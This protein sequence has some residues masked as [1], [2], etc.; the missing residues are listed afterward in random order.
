MFDGMSHNSW[1]LKLLDGTKR[2]A[3]RNAI[4]TGGISG[5]LNLRA[6]EFEFPG[7]AA[8]IDNLFA[9]AFLGRMLITLSRYLGESILSPNKSLGSPIEAYLYYAILAECFDLDVE[10]LSEK[11]EGSYRLLSPCNPPCARLFIDAQKQL[12]PY[13]VDFCLQGEAIPRKGNP[14]TPIVVECDGHDFHERDK[15]QVSKD[16]KRDRDLQQ[17]GFT[18][19]RYSGSD[20][21]KSLCVHAHEIVYA[22]CFSGNPVE[23]KE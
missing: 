11:P 23:G 7:R 13:R 15:E 5:L 9:Q 14:R 1:A 6:K 12:G 8:A 10:V 19:F 18:V 17:M 22:A 2:E 16:K 4:S 3:E 20:L 21:F